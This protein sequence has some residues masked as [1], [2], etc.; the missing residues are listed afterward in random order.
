MQITMVER[1]C[2]GCGMKFKVNLQ[3]KQTHHSRFC[4]DTQGD[5]WKREHKKDLKKEELKTVSV[6]VSSGPQVQNSE[7][8]NVL[9][10]LN[11]RTESPSKP[12]PDTTETQ[13]PQMQNVQKEP[14]KM[15]NEP[16]NTN[17]KTMLPTVTSDGP[18]SEQD[19][20]VEIQPMGLN[21]QLLT[22]L[23]EKFHMTSLL[24]SSASELH[25]HMKGMFANVPTPEE[26][27]RTY[28]SDKVQTACLCAK[29]IADLLRLKLDIVK[30]HHGLK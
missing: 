29:Q 11:E 15:Q 21:G 13:K 3:S 19:V 5:L 18:P 14:E 4:Q 1:E 20:S 9:K 28:D 30:A 27:I 8:K 7:R 17:E 10:D 12:A 23:Q 2:F 24:D 6:N 25:R 26:G 16:L 22:S